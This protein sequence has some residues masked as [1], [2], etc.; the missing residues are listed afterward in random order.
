MTEFKEQVDE[1]RLLLEA[2]EWQN[3]ITSVHIFNSDNT[4]VAYNYP[5]PDRQG[6][7][8]DTTYEDGR[9]E[10]FI[11]KDKSKKL[12]GE[13]LKGKELLKLYKKRGT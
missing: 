12:F 11:Y 1:Q 10:R 8:C 7:V 9:I 4:N 2:E 3:K 13:K 6:M 5:N